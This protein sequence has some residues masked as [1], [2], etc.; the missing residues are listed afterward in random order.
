MPI[1]KN[2]KTLC[3]SS[4]APGRR[5]HRS[6]IHAGHQNLVRA[7]RLANSVHEAY[8]HLDPSAIQDAETRIHKELFEPTMSATSWRQLHPNDYATSLVH[9]VESRYSTSNKSAHVVITIKLPIPLMC[10]NFT[11]LV[12]PFCIERNKGASG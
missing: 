3:T 1:R 7:R 11:D 10:K 2:L 8:V 4:S 12:G 6:S 9:I 5:E